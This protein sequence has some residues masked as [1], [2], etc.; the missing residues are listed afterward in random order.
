MFYR[1]LHLTSLHIT[2]FHLLSK[3]GFRYEKSNSGQGMMFA[4]EF[5]AQILYSWH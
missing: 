5:T 3:P 2:S 4:P 1:I